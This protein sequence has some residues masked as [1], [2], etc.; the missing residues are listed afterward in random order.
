[1]KNPVTQL[2]FEF[3]ST[4]ID[5]VVRAIK[6]SIGSSQYRMTIRTSG[7]KQTTGAEDR[8]DDAARKAEMGVL[9]SFTVHPEHTWIRYILVLRVYRSSDSHA[10]WMGT[11][12]ITNSEYTHLWNSLL[13]VHGLEFL[14]IGFEEGV[15]ISKQRDSSVAA[16]PWDDPFLVL[17]A[18]C[19]RCAENSSSWHIQKGRRY[20]ESLN[21]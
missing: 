18:V 7:G 13:E 17:G 12:E 10:V 9:S 19:D 8:I 16:F 5:P 4:A 21:P 20:L 6:K 11:I 3:G 2:V 1:V 14:C 15:D